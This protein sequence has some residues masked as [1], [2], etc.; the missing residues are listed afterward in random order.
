MGATGDGG[1]VWRGAGGG[2]WVRLQDTLD[3]MFALVEDLLVDQV[4][5]V[6]PRSAASVL[7]VGC[8]T[9]ATTVALARR[10]GPGTSVTGVDVSEAMLAAARERVAGA[11]LDGDTRVEFVAADAGHHPFDPGSADVIASRFGLMFF[12]DPLAA[13]A[14]LHGATRPGGAL[15]AIVWRGPEQN[16]FMTTAVDAAADVL[17]V[18]PR[19]PGAP[20][21]FGLA[22]GGRTARILGDAGWRDV[23][24]D[25]VD[26]DCSFPTRDLSAYLGSMGA[27]GLALA[28]HD[29]ATR[30]RVVDHVRPAF[31]PFV[32]GDE[33]RFVAAC[34]L[35]SAT[36]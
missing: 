32:H 23:A 18:T 22:D 25:P 17:T 15:R 13:F 34:W 8:G 12:D 7:D 35:L 5:G 10:L 9:G 20:G 21:Q 11:A 2:S 31:E 4:V 27:V 14:H 19:P 29:E 24:V 16:P 33:V 26:V 3:G 36:A 28:E 6:A 30:T 1:A